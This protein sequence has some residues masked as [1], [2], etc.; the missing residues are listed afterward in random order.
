MGASAKF[1]SLGVAGDI[2][3]KEEHSATNRRGEQAKP[4]GVVGDPQPERGA[5]VN[6][7]SYRH[8]SKARGIFPI[9]EGK[10]RANALTG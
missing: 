9:S 6:T 5:E 4:D 3:L 7:P 1:L 10:W 8:P 2:P